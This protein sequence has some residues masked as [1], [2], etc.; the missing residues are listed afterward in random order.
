MLIF[1]VMGLMSC[2]KYLNIPERSDYVAVKTASDCQLLLDDYLTMNASYPSDMIISSDEYFVTDGTASSNAESEG[3]YRWDKDAIRPSA[4]PAWQSPYKKVF[5]ANVVLETVAN[6]RKDNA[7]ASSVLDGLEGAALF[8]RAYN[9]FTLAQLYA[10]P[11]K[12][13]SDNGGPG[14]PIRVTSDLN[15][16]TSRGTVKGTYDRIVSDLK[17]AVDLLPSSVSIVSRPGKAAAYA[18]L[19]RCYLSM[20]DFTN[21]LASANAALGLHNTLLDYNTLTTNG[22]RYIQVRFN[23]EIIFQAVAYEDYYG[24]FSSQQV[25]V[26]SNL[27]A[28]YAGSDLRGKVFFSLSSDGFYKFIGSYDAST[29]LFVGLAVDEL[30]LTRA[31]CYARNGDAVKAMADLNT[32]LKSRYDNSGPYIDLVAS[33]P[34]DALAMILTERKKEL[35][36]R[37][38][39][40]TD[41]RRLNLNANTA[42][43]LTRVIG[44]VSYTLPPND[45]RYTLLIPKEVISTSSLAQ[46]AR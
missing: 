35:V 45:L 5:Q 22:S 37:G 44:G 46:N 39:R 2:Q 25:N 32:L 41:L 33:G 36:L 42:V 17:R 28:E 1:L 43:T 31:E 38:L 11:Y 20:S 6:L 24:F 30:Y 9:Y 21:A 7:E 34:E 8:F 18:L 40:W 19:S 29:T 26:D 4:D 27:L 15:E 14:I 10:D 13:S 23:P 16:K 3:F 12:P